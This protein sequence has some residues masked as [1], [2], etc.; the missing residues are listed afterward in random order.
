MALAL[1]QADPAARAERPKSFVT[2][3]AAPSIIPRIAATF[4]IVAPEPP[5]PSWRANITV[6]TI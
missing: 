6:P 1:S 5:S 3:I 2:I 4:P